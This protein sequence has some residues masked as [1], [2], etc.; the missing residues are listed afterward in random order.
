MGLHFF[1]ASS[2]SRSFVS[3]L[4]R[5]VSVYSSLAEDVQ[6]SYI[7]R[8]TA[9]LD[10]G[11]LSL[12]RRSPDDRLS[13]PFDGSGDRSWTVLCVRAIRD[14]PPLALRTGFAPP[15][16]TSHANAIDSPYGGEPFEGDRP[17]SM[18][19][20]LLSSILT[21]HGS[22]DVR[23]KIRRPLSRTG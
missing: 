15:P 3:R 11:R 2:R 7:P 18:R 16:H 4:S 23:V 9:R 17:H 10:S 8:P 12:R 6:D 20:R 19:L 22:Q 21:K 13:V 1:A 14:A 5:L